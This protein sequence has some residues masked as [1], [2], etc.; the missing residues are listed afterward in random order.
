MSFVLSFFASRTG[1]IVAGVVFAL[2]A[3]I[4]NN[5]HQRSI[6]AEKVV[7]KLEIT[8]MPE[9]I[10]VD[11]YSKTVALMVDAGL[12]KPGLDPATMVD[13]EQAR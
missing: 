7:A 3:L 6:G 9:W 13:M 4:V 10:F 2:V 11:E 1:G 8:P 5:S 12:L